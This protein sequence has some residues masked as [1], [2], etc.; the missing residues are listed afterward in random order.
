MPS[1]YDLD[2]Q[3]ITIKTGGYIKFQSGGHSDH[4][5]GSER[6]AAGTAITA[7]ATELNQ[8]DGTSVLQTGAV[9]SATEAVGA[10]AANVI[11]VAF[12]L[13]DLAGTNMAKIV[14]VLYY[15]S[16]SS[17][18]AGLAATAPDT[19]LAIGTDGTIIEEF[20]ADKSGYAVTDA[21]G[22][23]DFDV[24]ESGAGGNWY[25]VV[26]PLIGIVHKVSSIITFT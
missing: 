14:P 5:S 19:D 10:E 23:I 15:L 13:K 26:V 16:D 8:L 3:G 18:G 12:Q 4:E 25:L 1:G 9:G 7:N 17:T 21:T 24:S 20:T 22:S 2:D 6:R 11:N